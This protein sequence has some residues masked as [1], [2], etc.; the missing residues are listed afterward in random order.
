MTQATYEDL[1]AVAAELDRQRN[2]ENE[3][4]EKIPSVRSVLQIWPENNLIICLQFRK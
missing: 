3:K 1:A 2:F 4:H